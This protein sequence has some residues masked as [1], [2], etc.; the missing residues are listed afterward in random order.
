MKVAFI[1]GMSVCPWGG[2]EELWSQTASRLSANGHAVAVSVP[3]WR[4]P[5]EQ[6]QRLKN[7]RIKVRVHSSGRSSLIARGVGKIKRKMGE[8]VWGCHWLRRYKP[9]LVVISQGGITDGLE[10]MQFCIESDLPFVVISQ[11]NSAFW[12]PPDEMAAAMIEAYRKARKVFC[13][14]YHNLA[15]LER[16]L[17]THLPNAS[18]VWN[19]YAVP[20]HEPPA[21]PEETGIMRMACVA[22]LDPRAKGQD[23]LFEILARPRW[24]DRPIEL[25]CYGRGPCEQALR[26]LAG[27][28][29]LS[30]VE[31][32]GHVADVTAI[33]KYNHLLL[34][35]SRY[36]GLPLALVE[37]MWS[38]RPAV[39]TDV[40]G[41]A[42]LCVDG[43]T[44]FVA[45]APT[46]CLV[47]QALE[48]AWARM[49]EW[50]EL[51]KEARLRAEA[52]V[53]RD[54]VGEFC[55][56]LFGDTLS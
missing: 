55:R 39:V 25:N 32:R 31:F 51:G 11:C 7:G 12:W 43:K 13:V 24:R 10:W 26:G 50:Q 3:F 18:V 47:E 42:E 52:R 36:E 38:A 40:G 4:V 15:L 46:L 33:W 21:W 44:G 56:E 30:S 27:H 54:P 8:R 23:L 20:W 14:S 9:D 19:P 17:A 53:P 37:A 5:S 28:L 1:S 35:P 29:R 48:R 49:S 6:V 2:S 45:A 22:R 16:Q 34:L 41:N